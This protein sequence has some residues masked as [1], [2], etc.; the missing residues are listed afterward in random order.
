MRSTFSKPKTEQ[1]SKPKLGG[2]KVVRE[3]GKGGFAVVF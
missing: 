2:Y 1:S 3:I